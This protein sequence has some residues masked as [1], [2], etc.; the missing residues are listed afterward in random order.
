MNN[1]KNN[2][3]HDNYENA[4]RL[5]EETNKNIKYCCIQGPTGPRGDIG[6][7]GLQGENR[8]RCYT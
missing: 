6:L 8:K 5:I 2:C 7:M 1:N 4:K 3:L